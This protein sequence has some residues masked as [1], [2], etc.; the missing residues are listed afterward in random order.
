MYVDWV[1]TS[2]WT[3]NVHVRG[4]GMYKYVDWECTCTWTGYVQVRGLGMYKY[5]DWECTSTWTGNVQVRGL[6]MYKYVDWECTSTWT[7]NVQVTCS[8]LG[9][10][11]HAL[12]DTYMCTKFI[13]CWYCINIDLVPRLILSLGTRS[14][15]TSRDSIIELLMA[16]G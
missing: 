10:Y 3:G 16:S 8:G 13:L 1:C 12:Q 9:Q 2:T 11:V 15:I 5:V 7:G 4:L 14:I 6:G